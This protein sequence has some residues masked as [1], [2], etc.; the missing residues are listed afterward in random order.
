MFLFLFFKNFSS[1]TDISHHSGVNGH[2]FLLEILQMELW[3][4]PS[5]WAK[6]PQLIYNDFSLKGIMG[7]S[8][9]PRRGPLYEWWPAQGSKL[10][11]TWAHDDRKPFIFL[12]S[13][14]LTPFH[15]KPLDWE[16]WVHLFY[17]MNGLSPELWTL[18]LYLA[19]LHNWNDWHV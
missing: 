10:H 5:Q 8:N 1:S 12:Q 17:M 2:W 9:V 13:L 3:A 15:P 18:E 4:N 11:L 19:D 6:A 14:S 16:N 7:R